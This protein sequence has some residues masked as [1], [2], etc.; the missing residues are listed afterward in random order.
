[1]NFN[2][3]K[4]LCRQII[5]QYINIEDYENI[6]VAGGFFSKYCNDDYRFN[7]LLQTLKYE[8]D[9]DIFAIVDKK[10]YIKQWESN[11]YKFHSSK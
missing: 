8:Q 11:N 6:I 10:K 3:N 5:E 7:D 9:I 2:F 1:M 4:D